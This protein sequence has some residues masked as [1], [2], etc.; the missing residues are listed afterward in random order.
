MSSTIP[1]M[2]FR[3]ESYIFMHTEP[4]FELLAK[5]NLVKNLKSTSLPLLLNLYDCAN[6]VMI[7]VKLACYV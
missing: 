3:N 1:N 4:A 7:A 6:T 5:C 2:K